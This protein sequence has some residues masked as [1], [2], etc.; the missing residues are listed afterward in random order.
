M[1]ASASYP[2]S[3]RSGL[4]VQ[5]RA[6][7]SAHWNSSGRHWWNRIDLVLRLL[8]GEGVGILLFPSP[9]SCPRGA[10]QFL[11]APQCARRSRRKRSIPAAVNQSRSSLLGPLLVGRVVDFGKLLRRHFDPEGIELRRNL[12]VEGED[13]AV[14]RR[15]AVKVKSGKSGAYAPLSRRV[16]LAKADGR[17]IERVGDKISSQGNRDEWTGLNW[18]LQM[19]GTSDVDDDPSAERL[20]VAYGVVDRVGIRVFYAEVLRV[21]NELHP[22]VEVI[23][24]IIGK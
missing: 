22:G 12:G 15:V 5:S 6:H 13:G 1:C 18:V 16:V 21:V 7:R 2:P 8:V 17:P 23:S 4:F 3:E 9:H 24:R 10:G 11:T 14:L 19:R 20:N